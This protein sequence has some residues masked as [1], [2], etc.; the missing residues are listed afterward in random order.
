[1]CPQCSKHRL[2]PHSPP[3]DGPSSTKL[4]VSGGTVL[5]ACCV[6]G[7]DES[8]TASSDFLRHQRPPTRP[9]PP[10][11]LRHGT[12]HTCVHMQ[13]MH[14]L[15]FYSLSHPRP[16]PSRLSHLHARNL[17]P[18]LFPWNLCVRPHHFTWDGAHAHWST[19]CDACC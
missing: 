3:L 11:V 2:L 6:G 15:C 4:T 18:R 19:S 12:T 9:P 17:C 14:T 5:L 16:L 7:G 8:S 1:V 10:K 13:R